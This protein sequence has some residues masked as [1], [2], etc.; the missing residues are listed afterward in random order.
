[1]NIYIWSGQDSLHEPSDYGSIVVIAKDLERA[2]E[3]ISEAGL[4]PT[5]SAHREHPDTYK[6]DA[7]VE[8]I[9]IF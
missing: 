9:Y 5:C 2:R 7:L 8:A 4:L 1:M 6:V 3:K